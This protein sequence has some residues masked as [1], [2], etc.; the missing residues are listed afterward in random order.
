MARKAKGEL[1]GKARLRADIVE[2][3]RDQH[4]LG[5]VSAAALEKTTL[6][7]LG[8]EALPQVAALSPAAIAKVRKRAGVSQAVLAGFLNVKPHTVS[9]WEC[10]ERRPT[11]TALKLLHVVKNLGLAPLR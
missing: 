2:M 4:A 8:A 6:R 9:Q 11:G 7:M 10:G 3:Q 1:T 5:M